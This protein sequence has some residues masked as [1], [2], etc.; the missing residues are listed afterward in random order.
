MIQVYFSLKP[1]FFFIFIF[2]S[3]KFTSSSQA[4]SFL[5]IL[6]ITQKSV[7]KYIVFMGL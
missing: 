5:H 6:N 1:I 4:F 2:T 7:P 3:L